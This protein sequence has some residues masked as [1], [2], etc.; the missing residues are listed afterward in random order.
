MSIRIGTITDNLGARREVILGLKEG[1]KLFCYKTQR[2]NSGIGLWSQ[3]KYDSFEEGKTYT[4][5]HLTNWDGLMVAYV[6][7]EDSCLAWAT[8][9]TFKPV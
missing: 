1:D 8:P 6:V 2:S 5:H 4:V 7:D 9:E 3:E